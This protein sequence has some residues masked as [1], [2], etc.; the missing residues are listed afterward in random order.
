MAALL[1]WSIGTG[2]D[3]VGCLSG[4]GVLGHAPY[5]RYCLHRAEQAVRLYLAL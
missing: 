1:G 3:L 5:R 4:M 2:V